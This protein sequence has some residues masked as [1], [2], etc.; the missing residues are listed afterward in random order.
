[1]PVAQVLGS[2]GE[3]RLVSVYEK[4]IGALRVTM[5]PQVTL[6]NTGPS[7]GEMVANRFTWRTSAPRPFG[8]DR[9]VRDISVGAT[10]HVGA[11]QAPGRYEGVF[12]TIVEYE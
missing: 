9:V 5:P 1:M 4:G 12:P 3:L 6:R 11:Q 10:L 7:G 8:A 2:P